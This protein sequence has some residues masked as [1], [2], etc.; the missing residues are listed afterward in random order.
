MKN[1]SVTIKKRV[2]TLKSSSCALFSFLILSLLMAVS[3]FG[4]L[5]KEKI[6]VSENETLELEKGNYNIETIEIKRNGTI[7]IKGSCVI[8]CKNLVT[9][10]GARIQYKAGSDYNN[11]QKLLEF[12]ATNGGGMSGTL[13]FIGSGADG[14]NGD[15]GINGA[16]G[17]NGWTGMEVQSV[18]GIFKT[19]LPVSYPPK[20]G[21]DGQNGKRGD[22]G[23]EAMDIEIYISNLNPNAFVAITA[24]GGSGGDGGNGG[25]GGKGRALEDGRKGGNGGTGGN[26]G[27]GGDGGNVYAALIHGADAT[28]EDKK[29]LLEFL[30]NN[31][32]TLPGIPGRGGLGGNGGKSGKGGEG[33]TLI[34]LNIEGKDVISAKG[35][36]GGGGNHGAMGIQGVSG[37]VGTAK[38]ELLTYDEWLEKKRRYIE[39]IFGD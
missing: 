18:G 13:F 23:E 32:S 27:N 10:N 8:F 7:L 33:G 36:S 37:D 24:N 25:N 35:G 14:K 5:R 38:E 21:Q 30:H 29:R 9:E 11:E 31:I 22:D 16:D 4:Q 20:P 28:E 3:C 2:S 12:T 17:K 15:N 26:G 6:T 39:E 19:D 34:R 1:I